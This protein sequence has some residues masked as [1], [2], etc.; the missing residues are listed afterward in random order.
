MKV[1]FGLAAFGLGCVLGLGGVPVLAATGQ[2]ASATDAYGAVDGQATGSNA[3]DQKAPVKKGNGKKAKSK[4]LIPLG[5]G[6]E[7][8]PASAEEMKAGAPIPDVRT[9]MTDVMARQR[10]NDKIRENYTYHIAQTTQ[11]LDGGGQVKKTESAESDVFFVH[12]HRIERTVKKDGKPLTGRD[13]QKEQER[14]TKLVE[15]A[16]RVPQGEPL[17]GPNV[18]VSIT[19]LLEIMDASNPHREMFRGRSTLVFDFAGKKD[20]R[21]H[22]FAEDASKKIAGRMWIDEHDHAVARM[23]AHF[24]DNFHVGAGLL[25]NV[26]KGSSFYFDQAPVNGEI[27]F[28]TNAEGLV[29]ARVL[30]LKGIRQHVVEKDY[31][32][33]K[34]SVNSEPGETAA[35]VDQAKAA[36]KASEKASGQVKQ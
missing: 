35:V 10:N 28:P 12:T 9:L 36:A 1:T 26:Q 19:H 33:Q 3:V 21:T 24:I 31:G 16:E 4:K 7:G 30:L 15:K 32:Y 14:I 13:E 22:G 34:F 23:E 27:W 6:G 29:E 25:A 8:V 18:N 17:E 11:E 20:A 5:T 2:S